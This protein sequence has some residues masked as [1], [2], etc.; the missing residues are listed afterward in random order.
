M[1]GGRRKFQTDGLF[2]Q[3]RVAAQF[4]GSMLSFYPV[5]AVSFGRPGTTGIL[6]TSFWRLSDGRLRLLRLRP[7]GADALILLGKRR[8]RPLHGAGN[9]H[10]VERR[11]RIS[12]AASWPPS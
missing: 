6:A 11:L 5:L 8:S 10:A 2:L 4:S 3:Q 12:S 7:K 1:R 9:H